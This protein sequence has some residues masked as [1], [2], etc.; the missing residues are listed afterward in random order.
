MNV[1]PNIL[2]T[3]HKGAPFRR[4]WCEQSQPTPRGRPFIMRLRQLSLP[5]GAASVKLRSLPVERVNFLSAG[6]AKQEGRIVGS[7]TEPD[8]PEAGL[9]EVFQ[10]GHSLDL[11]VANAYSHHR[12]LVLLVQEVNIVA[13]FRPV[14]K[15]TGYFRDLSPLLSGRVEKHK[16]AGGERHGDDVASIGRP[17]GRIK[18][19]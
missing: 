7:H 19:L 5:V 4:W 10:V 9:P 8:P 13:V 18:A 17:A 16:A 2:F 14:G 12:W 15:P 6:V 1:E 3:V 11:V